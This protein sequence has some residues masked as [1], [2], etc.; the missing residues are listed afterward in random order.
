MA[1][2]PRIQTLLASV[3]L[4]HGLGE[5]H[6]DAIAALTKRQTY[7]P[8]RIVIRQGEPSDSLH[9]VESGTYEVFYWDDLLRI[10]R[11][12]NSLG[13]GDVFGE[14]G[15]LS[16]EPRSASVRCR[17]AGATIILGKED[18]LQFL[19]EHS[20]AA[21][22][23]AKTLAQR[24][25]AA[26]RSRAIPFERVA[27]FTIT[28]EVAQLLPLKLILQYRLLPLSLAGDSVRIGMVDPSDLVARNTASV[29]LSRYQTEWVCISLSDPDAM[30]QMSDGDYIII[31]R[32]R[33][34]FSN[35]AIIST[36]RDHSTPVAELKLGV[37]PSAKIYEVQ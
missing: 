10:E 23:L 14:M 17:D 35:D 31:A 11:P 13:R 8:G 36:L 26:N 12:F 1:S 3:D 25:I 6:L 27:N 28:P 33:R 22:A 29:F 5:V 16:G 15:V 9:L 21:V 34:Y 24:V 4:F 32:G 20:R 37:I 7:E 19:D 18:F 2:E 30:K